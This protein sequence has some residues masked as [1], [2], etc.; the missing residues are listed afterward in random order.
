MVTLTW[1]SLSG[2]VPGQ[3]YLRLR[4]STATTTM[5]SWGTGNDGAFLATGYAADGEVEDYAVQI[6]APT[7]VS[8]SS[9]NAL[10]VLSGLADGQAGSWLMAL[11]L[12]LAYLWP[13]VLALGLGGL[14]LTWRIRQQRIKRM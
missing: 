1:S 14:M 3:S 4:L 8:L 13:A 9:F 10:G 2:L 7:V 6:Y 12:A 5:S 11:G